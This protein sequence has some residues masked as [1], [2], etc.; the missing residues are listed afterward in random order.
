M[1]E[2]AG[3]DDLGMNFLFRFWS[4]YLY[5]ADNSGGLIPYIGPKG[6]TNPGR[7]GIS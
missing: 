6:G 1:G 3:E 7:S 5:K 4:S 2:A